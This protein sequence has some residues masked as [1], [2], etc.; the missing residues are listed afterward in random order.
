M[1]VIEDKLRQVL[2]ALPRYEPRDAQNRMAMVVDRALSEGLSAVIEAGT[3]SGKTMAYLVPLLARDEK[4]V[5]STGTIALQSQLMDKDLKFLEEHYGRPFKYALAKGRGNYFC[6]EHAEEADRTLPPSGDERVQLD[7]VMDLWRSGGWSG[8]NAELPFRVEPRLWRQE[9]TSTSEDCHGSRCVHYAECPFVVARRQLEEADVIVANHALYLMDVAS[10]GAV[11]PRH[12][13]VVFDEA[14]KLEESA[15][16]AFTMTI[17]KNATRHLLHRIH[18]RLK[19]LPFDLEKALVDADDGFQ[20]WAGRQ[21]GRSR[22]MREE[23]DL[24]RVAVEFTEA[25]EDLRV[26]IAATRSE[27]YELFGATPEAAR[28]RA[29]AL[30]DALLAQATSLQ[31]RWQHFAEA[32]A[33]TL[34]ADYVEWLEFSEPRGNADEGN[35]AW[36]AIHSAPL[37]V[38]AF[39]SE[40]LWPHKVA[41][42]TS[43]TLAT[44]GSL[45]YIRGRLGLDAAMD[46]VLPSVFDY[47][48]QAVL[49]VPTGLPSPNDSRYVEAV[50]RAAVPLLQR[51][52]GHCL[53]LFTSYRAL[54]EAAALLREQNLPYPIRTQEDATRPR[55]LAWFRGEQN[56]VLLATASFW[57]GVDIP[58]R[59]LSCVIIDRLPFAHPDDPVVQAT[60]ER[61][62]SEGRDWFNDYSLPNAILSLKQGFG[63]LIRG[64]HDTG[65]VCI[66]DPRIINARYGATVIRSLPPAPVVRSLDHPA[67]ERL[68]PSRRG[69]DAV[70]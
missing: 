9:L 15:I 17:P 25:L 53:M 16:S 45:T 20:E 52:E 32:F 38:A 19:G 2:E 48:S 65:V 4:A 36:F 10:G 1:S 60:T 66:M 3:G 26:C 57:E 62:K 21:K 18:R 51:T 33:G 54:R 47:A 42:L 40:N 28:S 39:L 68:F 11:L 69:A 67:L 27:E 59:Q 41:V 61:L 12:R 37:D 34:G 29:A 14:H 13:F 64:R 46:V 30:K 6:P 23:P 22:R 70:A 7:N 49:Y 31:L 35:G 8:D 43:A 55:L 56:P 24:H 58:G 5:V 63:R 44:N 50:V